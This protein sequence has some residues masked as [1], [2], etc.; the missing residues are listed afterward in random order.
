MKG[1]A[2]G[3]VAATA[4]VLVAAAAEAFAQATFKVPFPFQVVSVKLPKGEYR[5]AQMDEGHLTLRQEATGREFQI[6]FTKRLAQPSPPP[7][8]P[9]LVFDVVGG[10]APSKTEYVTDYLVAEVWL[11]GMD[12]FLIHTLKGAHQ[13][14]ILKGQKGQ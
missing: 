5:L 7:A 9:Q 14:Q 6:S 2:I 8:E 1:V 4:L 11:P 10:F 12:G 3:A 13:T